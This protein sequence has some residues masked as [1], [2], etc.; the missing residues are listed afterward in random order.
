MVLLLVESFCCATIERNVVQILLVIAHKLAFRGGG[1]V[2]W[3]RK[4]V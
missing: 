4:E 1:T 3:S 2:T